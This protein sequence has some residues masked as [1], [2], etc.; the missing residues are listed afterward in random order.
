MT[1]RVVLGRA[2]RRMARRARQA[3]RRD[4]AAVGIAILLVLA[5][6]LQR[7][8]SITFDTKL[9]LVV[10]PA[11]FL[12][13]ALRPWSPDINLGSL[14]NQAVGY[15]FPIG[16]F[17]LAG[18]VL[19]VPTW[20]WQRLW[21]GLVLVVAFDGMRR[22]TRAW[23]VGGDAA[24]IIAGLAYALSPRVLT[25]VGVISAE[26][27]PGAILP[28]TVLPL[29]LAARSRLRW[30]HG[31]VLSAA[32]VPLMS[33]VNATEV[34]MILPLPA[35]IILGSAGRVRARLGRVAVW[36][37]FVLVATAWWVGPLLVQ[38]RYASP[39]LDFIESARATTAPI[40]WLEAVR[41]V[42][43]WVAFLPADVSGWAAGAVLVE[44]AP[45]VLAMTTISA[46]GLA[47]LGAARLRDRGVVWVAL[48]LGLIVVTLGHGGVAGSPLSEVFRSVLDGPGA[49]F[50]N[51]HKVDPMI[52]MPLALG[53]AAVLPAVARTIEAPIR[54]VGGLAAPR[55]P[56]VS[57]ALAAVAVV[58]A[59]VL[60]SAP[61]FSGSVRAD[62]GWPR[63]PAAWRSMAATMQALPAGSRVLVV[64]AA[65]NVDQAWGRTVDEPIQTIGG[66]SWVSR[67]Q[68]P[69]IGVGGMRLVDALEQRL[70]SGLPSDALAG[71]LRRVGVSHVLFRSDLNPLPGE[72]GPERVLNALRG[73]P[74]LEQVASSGRGRGGLSQLSLWAVRGRSP[75]VSATAFAT[76]R[77][78]RG[79]SEDV[80]GLVETRSVTPNERLV[81][82]ASATTGD[83]VG[84]A[85]HPAMVTDS[86]KLRERAFGRVHD[87][88]SEVLGAGTSWSTGRVANDFAPIPGAPAPSI[89]WHPDIARIAASSSASSVTT[90]GPVRPAEQPLAALDGDLTTR[91]SSAPFTSVVGQWWEVVLPAPA[92]LREVSVVVDTF[93]APV[94]RLRVATERASVDVRVGPGGVARAPTLD[95]TTA[96]RLRIT[97]LGSRST[98][99]EQVSIAE[100][101]GL[102]VDD[103]P[104]LVVS[105]PVRVGDTVLL[106]TDPGRRACT[107][108]AGGPVC[109]VGGQRGAEESRGPSRVVTFAERASWSVSGRAIATGGAAVDR[110]LDPVGR[111]VR[112]KASSVLGSDPLV[113]ASAAVDADPGTAW[114][115]APGDPD[116]S[117]DLAWD[118]RRMVSRVVLTRGEGVPGGLPAVAS[119][120]VDGV[121]VPATI[122]GPFV[123]LSRPT[124][125]RR[126][127]I[128]LRPRSTSF[129]VAEVSVAG[130]DGLK[131]RVDRSAATGTPCGLGPTF[132]V[133]GRR[134]PTRLS[135][136]IGDLRSGAEFDILPCAEL[137]VIPAGRA[138]VRVE[139]VAGFAVRSMTLRPRDPPGDRQVPTDSPVRVVENG[140]SHREVELDP[141]P[142]TLLTVAENYNGG[143]RATLDGR[144]LTAVIVDGW[145]QGWR[146]PAGKARAVR[147]DYAPMPF[148]RVTIVVGVV[149][150]AALLLAGGLIVVRRRPAAAGPDVVPDPRRRSWWAIAGLGGVLGAT[151]VLAGPGWALGCVVGVLLGCIRPPVA[152]GTGTRSLLG[153]PARGSSWGRSRRE[154]VSW[155]VLAL[156]VMSALWW[157]A[158]PDHS[159]A[160]DVPGVLAAAAVG[161]AVGRCAGEA[162]RGWRRGGG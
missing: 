77:V 18:E 133:A 69:L 105:S 58:A 123:E 32:S 30:R 35:L 36:A 46:L 162:M 140:A 4:W 26:T 13:A 151:G 54:R 1:S 76:T 14:Q 93:A 158:N 37:L 116:P 141:G 132:V 48:L 72:P 43:H 83:D 49:P 3:P 104:A 90:F 50:R 66:V 71:A 113:T 96:S 117:L 129:G 31:V 88:V 53:L 70:A 103:P 143:W 51:V 122:R 59:L 142:E 22:L 126:I 145:A 135:G 33:G 99:A 82:A 92:R 107:G 34:L 6:V 44:R 38:G 125:G 85:D 144:Q 159:P 19:G 91:W 2:W 40:G 8:G 130:V 60:A 23:P 78:F 137:P 87:A 136:S 47:G 138:I 84:S 28:W 80:L 94:T 119:L 155:G 74:G 109:D 146:V 17:F 128:R 86:P 157:L 57:R 124:P 56:V 73:S 106:G 79:A 41:G 102:P 152:G 153:G 139:P 10:D 39:F 115:A 65:G 120:E 110:L 160:A 111:G 7:P 147:L 108:G 24:S 161:A 20:W 112:A 131:V 61:L 55:V 42:T 5:S 68:V 100:V 156:I 62:E 25:T 114:V 150:M 29:V 95:G 154:V 11:R 75:V 16:P 63:F 81:S 89:R 21:S 52:R 149:A 45:L 27:L 118:E 134:V 148:F 97:V 15:L 64:P 98:G 121:V 101:T 67:S 12:G 127:T 9:D